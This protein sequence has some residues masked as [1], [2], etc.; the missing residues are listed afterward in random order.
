MEPLKKNTPRQR[1]G[2]IKKVYMDSKKLYHERRKN[3]RNIFN[4]RNMFYAISYWLLQ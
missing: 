4:N 3:E 2:V 1:Q